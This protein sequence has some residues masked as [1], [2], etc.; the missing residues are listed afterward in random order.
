MFEGCGIFSYVCVSC[1]RVTLMLILHR[2]VCSTINNWRP[3][4]IDTSS[5]KA[6][7]KYLPWGKKVKR[8]SQEG[9]DEPLLFDELGQLDPFLGISES[10]SHRSISSS[11][12][13]H[14]HY[15][16][17]SSPR[18]ERPLETQSH[19]CPFHIYEGYGT[20]PLSSSKLG[21]SCW[22]VAAS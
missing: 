18:T 6:V 8:K 14:A 9:S 5:M 20:E 2:L 4:R 17:T 7:K 16:L 22:R 15:D 12:S 3:S 1:P 13:F 19:P 11:N 21:K 10:A